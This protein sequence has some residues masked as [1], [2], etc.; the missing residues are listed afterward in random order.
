MKILVYSIGL[1]WVLPIYG[2]SQITSLSLSD[3]KIQELKAGKDSTYIYYNLILNFEKDKI[4]IRADVKP[5]NI[6]DAYFD[7]QYL[8]LVFEGEDNNHYLTGVYKDN[9]KWTKD[10][11]YLQLGYETNLTTK[12]LIS[13]KFIDGETLLLKFSYGYRRGKPEKKQQVL[14]RLGGQGI[15]EYN[16]NLQVFNGVSVTRKNSVRPID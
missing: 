12:K 10:Y 14:W 9:G 16:Y 13:A 7:N 15:Y 11:F 1:I 8:V 5:I 6:E 3:F 2:Y 4:V